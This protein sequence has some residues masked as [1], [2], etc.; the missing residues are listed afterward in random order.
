MPKEVNDI[1]EL[2]NVGH[3]YD[4]LIAGDFEYAHEEY[5]NLLWCIPVFLVLWI[6]VRFLPFG[7]TFKIATR[8]NKLSFD[9]SVILA[10][11]PPVLVSLA[12]ALLIVALAQPQKSDEKSESYTEGI[13]IM[14]ALDVSGS[15]EHKDLK[16]NRIEALKK[17]AQEFVDGRDGDKIGIVV[18]AEEAYVKI[19]LTTDYDLLKQ[20]ISDIKL[21]DI[22]MEGTAIG[23]GIGVCVS[24]LKDSKAESKVIIL[25][26]DGENTAGK[27]KPE[28]T[29]TMAAAFGCRIYAIGVGGDK[30]PVEYTT[31]FGRTQTQWVPSN[32]NEKDLQR[33][34]A[35]GNGEYFRASNNKAL[36]NIFD[37]I[38]KLEKTEIKEERFKET[39]D[40]YHIYLAYGVFFLLL[41]WSTKATFLTNAIQD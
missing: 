8:D 18:F 40:Y 34:A 30:V 14:L 9:W 3:W 5:L 10:L 26:S 2:Y 6:V 7:S 31:F 29:S 37:K 23:D 17:V 38:N 15:M 20:Q 39:T 33:I 36:K 27:L 12:A 25:I 22:A 13:E 35:N 21:G 11:I 24:K 19:P 28:K 4:Q 32:F 1:H 16:P 41:W